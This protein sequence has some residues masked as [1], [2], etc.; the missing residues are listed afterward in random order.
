MPP[1]QRPIP[2]PLGWYGAC[3]AA[4][5]CVVI[6]ATR[7]QGW[8]VFVALAF[9]SLGWWGRQDFGVWTQNQLTVA[10]S[11]SVF[12]RLHQNIFRAFDY[13]DEEAVYSA[14]ATSV[15][16]DLLQDLYLQ[17]FRHL[18]MQD[19]GGAVAKIE[20]VEF[21]S[22]ESRPTRQGFDFRC[23]WN[24]VGTVEHWGH[25]HQRTHQFDADFSVELRGEAWKITR[26]QGLD[27][28]QIGVK[29]SLRQF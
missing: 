8:L 26:M 25:I 22:G 17:I 7:R 14:L 6:A 28:R 10:E 18:Q 29:T 13:H 3:A 16:G 1:E 5:L 21:I 9:V 20:Q 4:A 23:T 27:E 19:Q 15:D 12:R 2:W 24:L 11:D